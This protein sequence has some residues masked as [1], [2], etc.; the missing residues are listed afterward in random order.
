MTA[1]ATV[2][3]PMD[4]GKNQKPQSIFLKINLVVDLKY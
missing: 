2:F 4:T 3:Q 1:T